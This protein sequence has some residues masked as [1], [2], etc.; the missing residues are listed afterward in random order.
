MKVSRDTEIGIQVGP[1]H[2]EYGIWTL[3]ACLFLPPNLPSS[4]I[5]TLLCRFCSFSPLARNWLGPYNLQSL[6]PLGF[7]LKFTKED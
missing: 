3:G 4:W 7:H 6:G 2:R 1:R 5:H